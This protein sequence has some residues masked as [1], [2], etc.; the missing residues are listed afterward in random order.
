MNHATMVDIGVMPG[1]TANG[2]PCFVAF[3][4]PAKVCIVAGTVEKAIELCIAKCK[5]AFGAKEAYFVTIPQ[6]AKPTDAS[7]TPSR[8]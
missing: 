1:V 5:E 4:P 2:N 8:N 6:P 7:F 3:C